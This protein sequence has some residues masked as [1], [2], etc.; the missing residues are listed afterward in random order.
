MQEA[1]FCDWLVN[2]G[3]D[4]HPDTVIVDA[5]KHKALDRYPTKF[6]EVD[7]DYNNDARLTDFSTHNFGNITPIFG[8]MFIEAISDGIPPLPKLRFGFQCAYFASSSARYGELILKAY[9]DWRGLVSTT[10]TIRVTI[11]DD[12]ELVDILRLPNSTQTHIAQRELPFQQTKLYLWMFFNA[13]AVFHQRKE[14]EL[15]DYSR[16]KRR[17]IERKTGKAPSPYFRI[18]DASDK[19]QKRYAGSGAS[20]GR[21]LEKAHIVRGH[22]RHTENHPLEQFNG[23]FWIPSHMK[24]KG[25]DAPPP[26]YKIVLRDSE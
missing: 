23:T 17:R 9:D 5:T 1:T 12:G 10:D 24:G 26:R 2:R 16:Q 15:V 18:L 22:F 3:V 7:T 4:F 21:T 8:S 19:P 11:D 20:T 6:F 25:D 13:L 14:I